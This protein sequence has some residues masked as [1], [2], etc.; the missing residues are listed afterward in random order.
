MLSLFKYFLKITFISRVLFLIIIHLNYYCFKT[1]PR[2]QIKT[3][4]NNSNIFLGNTLVLEQFL[5][6]YFEKSSQPNI[7]DNNS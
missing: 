3:T 6:T 1:A 7:L 2:K 5:K 4:E